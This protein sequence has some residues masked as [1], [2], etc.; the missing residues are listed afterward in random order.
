M[1]GLE[2][3]GTVVSAAISG[4]VVVKLIDKFFLSRTTERGIQV[5]T[6]M[7][8]V[9]KE[10][11]EYKQKYEEQ[12]K[13][14]LAIERELMQINAD[15]LI[16]DRV[17][18]DLPF[19]WWLKDS[20]LRMVKLNDKYEEV[21]LKP[22]GKTRDDYINRTDKEVWGEE[23]GAEYI[24]NDLHVIETRRLYDNMETV[25]Y[26]GEIIKCRV[27][28]YPLFFGDSIIGVCGQAITPQIE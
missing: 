2:L 23:L 6:I 25:H 18:M 16:F 3:A 7:Q 5:D 24:K 28:K 15:R 4:G 12:L 17:P 26:K 22:L 21:F 10:R 8:T 1:S 27:V 20:N 14:N 9:V 11:D 13:F 19:P